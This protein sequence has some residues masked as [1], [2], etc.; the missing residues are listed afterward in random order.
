M[1][2]VYSFDLEVTVVG[3]EAESVDL[4]R[5]MVDLKVFQ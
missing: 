2:E 4:E 5:V 1:L 3:R